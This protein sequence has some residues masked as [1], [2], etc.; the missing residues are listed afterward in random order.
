MINKSETINNAWDKIEIWATKKFPKILDTL[1]VGA[2]ESQING[3]NKY[4]EYP[5]PNS[6]RTSLMRHNGQKS[7][8]AIFWYMDVYKLLTVEEITEEF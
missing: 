1:L 2:T 8:P 3:L 6:F 7:H 4:L 5:L